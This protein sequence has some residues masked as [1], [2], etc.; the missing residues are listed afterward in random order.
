MRMHA[1]H[2][3]FLIVVLELVYCI[4]V[5]LE[6]LHNTFFIFYSIYK[7]N[8]YNETSTYRIEYVNKLAFMA[9]PAITK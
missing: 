3:M 5:W 2:A 6:L 1:N 8:Q 9:F 4:V 7:C